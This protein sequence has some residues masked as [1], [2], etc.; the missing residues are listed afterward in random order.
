[1][2]KKLGRQFWPGLW[3]YFT[4][5]IGFVIAAIWAEQYLLAGMDE[6]SVEKQTLTAVPWGDGFLVELSAECHEQIGQFVEIP[7]E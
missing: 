4:V 6:G 3:V 2:N 1:M 5:L 7:K